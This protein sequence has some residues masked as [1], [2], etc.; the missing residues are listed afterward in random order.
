M[1]NGTE[2]VTA[3][4][5]AIKED[6]QQ[7][8]GE[9]EC[10]EKDGIIR[11]LVSSFG[12]TG[13]G[14]IIEAAVEALPNGDAL[15]Y[16]VVHF[17]FTLAKDIDPEYFG[18]VAG[19]LNDL[20]V[21][22]QVGEFPSFG[23]FCLYKPLKQIVYG[24][25]MPINVDAFEAE[26][27]NIRFF[28]ATVFDQLDIFVDLIQLVAQGI[29]ELTA[30]LFITYLEGMKNLYDLQERLEV[31]EKMLADLKNETPKA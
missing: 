17:N 15:Q 9:D 25:R 8:C 11:V 3:V 27:E 4:K 16:P 7:L 5:N 21:I 13:S 29:E 26:R 31:I 1:D 14:A 19:L 28:L 12:V 30:E 10:V 6:L 24:Y 23:T 20:N 2:F 22:F 18:N